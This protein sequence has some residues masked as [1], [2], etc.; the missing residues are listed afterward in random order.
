[1]KESHQNYV[2]SVV[3]PWWDEIMETWIWKARC[4]ADKCT[5]YGWFFCGV[6]CLTDLGNHLVNI[7]QYFRLGTQSIQV[8]PLRG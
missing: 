6:M 7:N 1:M 8:Y 2:E 5:Y 3:Y 4:A